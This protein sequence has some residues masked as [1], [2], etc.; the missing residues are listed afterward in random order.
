MQE[1]VSIKRTVNNDTGT[2]NLCSECTA[3]GHAQFVRK[4]SGGLN[5]TSR[6]SRQN[7]LLRFQSDLRVTSGVRNLF[8]IKSI[9]QF[10]PPPPKEATLFVCN[11]SH[12]DITVY[13]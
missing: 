5:A 12:S 3:K 10:I 9:K 13:S 11:L 4:F 8:V 1:F 6:N 7:G 2:G